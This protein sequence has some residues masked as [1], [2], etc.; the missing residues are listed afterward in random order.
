MFNFEGM[1]KPQD[2]QIISKSQF[3]SCN[4]ACQFSAHDSSYHLQQSV[5]SPPYNMTDR[6]RF[7]E[8]AKIVVS[9]IKLL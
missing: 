2:H 7:N 9:M 4:N 3:T 8:H 5:R 1:I 6:K